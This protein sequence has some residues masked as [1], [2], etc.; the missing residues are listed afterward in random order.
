M[1]HDTRFALID[2]DGDE[3]FAAIVDGTFQIG[4]DRKNKP[5][6][7]EQFARAI[8]GKGAAGT[9]RPFFTGAEADH[10][11]FGLERTEGGTR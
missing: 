2:R 10:Q 8:T 5:N 7:L 6:S 11:E 1:A 4:K 9:I 3:R